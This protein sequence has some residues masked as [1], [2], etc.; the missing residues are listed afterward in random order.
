MPTRIAGLIFDLDGTLVDSALDFDAMR[1]E[2][3]LPPKQPILESLD[4]M[5]EAEALRCRDILA[6][7]EWAGAE[8]AVLMPGA[9]QFLQAL[10]PLGL[11]R[12]LLT[13]NSRAIVERTLAR[14]GLEFEYIVAREDAPAKPD[15]TAIHQICATWQLAPQQVAI[16]GD[17]RFDL[18]AGRRAG[19][20]TVLYTA[21]RPLDAIPYLDLADHLLPSF[22]DFTAFCAWLGHTE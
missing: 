12:A 2:M 15:P 21:G 1:A 10:E 6:R 9:A 8:R 3:G 17:Y 22:H 11:H 16:V 19:I 4:K 5:P 14:L 13:R 20:R 7:H 18:E